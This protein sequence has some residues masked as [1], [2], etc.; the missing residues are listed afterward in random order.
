MRIPVMQGTIRRR[1][2]ANY[3]VAPEALIPHL[4]APFRPKLVR[5]HAVAG[6]CLIGLAGERP[7]GMPA[8][9]GLA[10]ENAAH[11]VAVE[12]DEGGVVREG[13]Y[14]ARRD[15]NSRLN[16]LVGGRL[17]PGTHHHA[18]FDVEDDGEHVK[19]A[20]KSDDGEVPVRVEG[21]AADA[22]PAGSMFRSL[23]E[24]S[25]FF[26]AGSLGYSPGV[27]GELDG[28]EL[29]TEAWRV[30]PLDVR[31]VESSFFDDPARFPPGTAVFDCALLMRDV[32]HE[33]HGRGVMVR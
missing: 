22:L 2:L 10:S 12:W 11:R 29:R 25:A 16:A 33:W 30:R 14:I 17:F 4:P 7:R 1:V 18:R 3:R 13:V 20:L 8:F 31:V 19:V 28:L 15:S 6:I 24:A 23:Q 21:R 9:L 5:G 26:E 27:G 32:P